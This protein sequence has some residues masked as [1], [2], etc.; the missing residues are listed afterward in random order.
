MSLSIFSIVFEIA[1]LYP[2]QKPDGTKRFCGLI[3]RAFEALIFDVAQG[4]MCLSKPM[5]TA[6]GSS[7]SLPEINH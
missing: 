4:L 7:L 5:N 2:V 6:L 3:V 1:V